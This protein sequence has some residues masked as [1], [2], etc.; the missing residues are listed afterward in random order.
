LHLVAPDVDA[1]GRRG[2]KAAASPLSLVPKPQTTATPPCKEN[3][4]VLDLISM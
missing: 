2:L 3:Y 1:R 4:P